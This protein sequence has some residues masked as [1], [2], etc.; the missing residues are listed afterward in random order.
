MRK[1]VVAFLGAALLATP[2]LADLTVNMDLGTLGAGVLNLAGDTT[3]LVNNCDYYDGAATWLESGPEYVYEF[4]I[5]SDM[6]VDMVQNL[7]GSPDLDHF[8]LDSLVTTWDGT[9]NRSANA[10]G[11]VDESSSFGMLAAGTYYLSVDGYSGAEGLYDFDLTFTEFVPPEPPVALAVNLPYDAA[12]NIAAADDVLW[13]SFDA[14]ADPMDIWT[15]GA[16]PSPIG[17]TEIGLY[18]SLGNLVANNDDGG[19]AGGYYSGLMGQTL[20]PG[21]YYLAVGGYNTSFSDGWAVDGGTAT[22]DLM[23]HITPEP[24][25]LLLLAIGALALRRR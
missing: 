9:Y 20:D 1:L 8:V 16:D 3:G 13:F 22:G 4:A 21:T 15:E 25:S 11:F 14:S 10:V 24:A 12:Q 2:A 7:T 19:P 23:L 5:A 18:D 6:T 17:D